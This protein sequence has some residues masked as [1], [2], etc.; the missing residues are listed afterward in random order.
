LAAS[1][2]ALFRGRMLERHI[3]ENVST[4]RTL[5]YCSA[6]E[7]RQALVNLIGNAIDAM[8]DGGQLNVRISSMRYKG[9]HCARIT[10][11]DT[12]TGIRNE[13]RQNLF[14]QFFTTKGSR[15]TGLGL[16][17]TR[18][19]VQRNHGTLRFRSRTRHPSGTAFAIYLPATAPLDLVKGAQPRAGEASSAIDAA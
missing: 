10:V 3:S 18:D 2:V 17:L 4:R 9:A 1:A 5:A 8:P 7:I 11:A 6:G 12:G 15:G 16:W 14:T 19:I 13:I